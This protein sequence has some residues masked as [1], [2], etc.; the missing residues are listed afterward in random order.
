MQYGSM[1]NRASQDS[2]EMYSST[3][4]LFVHSKLFF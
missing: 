1:N 4:E 2:L 3:R